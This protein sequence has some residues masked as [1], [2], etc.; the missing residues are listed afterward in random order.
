MFLKGVTSASHE[1]HVAQYITE[2]AAMATI[3]L[4]MV[5]ISSRFTC[6][7]IISRDVPIAKVKLYLKTTIIMMS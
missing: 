7:R 1:D 3:Y 4:N 2:D 5:F 6:F